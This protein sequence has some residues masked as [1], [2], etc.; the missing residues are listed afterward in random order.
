[1]NIPRQRK[2]IMNLHT[3]YESMVKFFTFAVKKAETK[4][5]Q[6]KFQFQLKISQSMVALLEVVLMI[7]DEK[8][9]EGD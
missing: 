5:D 3:E 4:E 1:M 6:D 9:V 8:G 7:L 2:K